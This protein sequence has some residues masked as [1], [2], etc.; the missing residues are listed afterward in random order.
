MPVK[1]WILQYCVMALALFAIF[2][3]VQY[4]KG[5]D[6]AYSLGFGALWS[7]ISSSIFLVVRIRNYRN[8]IA[9]K[10]CNDLPEQ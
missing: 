8:R 2:S 10:V 6:L 4:M 7:F 3:A 9:C 1:K 5:H